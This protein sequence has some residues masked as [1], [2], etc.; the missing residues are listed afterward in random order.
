M[1]YASKRTA[2]GNSIIK[3]QAIQVKIADMASKLE[4]SRL[5]TW[6]AAYLK[7]Q[8]KPYTKVRNFLFFIFFQTFVS[9]KK[10]KYLNYSFLKR[11]L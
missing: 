7:D 11:F 2:F 9:L 10:F 3:L 6:R 8:G 5:L 4:S 1:E